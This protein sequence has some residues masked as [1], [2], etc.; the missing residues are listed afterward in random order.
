M[1]GAGGGGPRTATVAPKATGPVALPPQIVVKDLAELLDVTTNE[2][3]RDLIGIGIFAAINEVVS[4]ADAAKVAEQLGFEPEE[5]AVPAP[6]PAVQARPEAEKIGAAAHATDVGRVAR[7]PV[8]TVMGHVDHG[9]TS[10]L[11]AIRNTRVAAGEAGGITQHIG[12]YQ[13]EVNGRKVTFLDTPGHE[14]FTQMRARGAQV[15]DVAVIVVAA[16]DGVMPQ[17]IE[18]IDHARAANVPLIVALNKID[19]QNANP[20]FV[21]QQLADNNV[22]IEEY[23]GDVVLVPVSAKK[24]EGIKE[25][26]EMIL[27]VADLQDVKA[28]P[29][30][31]AQGTIIEARLD[32]ASGVTATVLIQNGS[33]KIGDIVVVGTTFGRV[34]A[35]FDDTGKRINKALPS[36][37]VSILGLSEVPSA[38]DLL[39]A[40]SDE[41]AARAL[42]QERRTTAQ[43]AA[44]Q[45]VSLDSL[46][47]QMR[48]GKVKELNLLL[49]TDVQGSVEAIRHGLTQ[50]GESHADE[51]LKVRL[52]HDAVGNVSENDVHLAAASK[53]VIIAFNVKVDSAAQRQAAV[54]GVDIRNYNVIY[55]MMDDIEAALTGL[56]EPVYRE[57][58]DGHAEVVQTFK[59]G[60]TM[61]IAGCRVTD[62][63][64]ARS[65]QVRLLRGG[66]TVF[67]GLIQSL[68]RGK[69][70][71]REVAQGFEC[72]IV[73]EDYNELE[74]GD[75]VETY[76]RVRV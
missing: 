7:A 52:I 74:V 41:K 13:V 65:S 2:V 47:M 67:T 75:V 60:R 45:S 36:M 73:L 44:G 72:G 37:P 33:L 9:K 31:K 69:D 5:A 61:I 53:A 12:A 56:L 54:D 17:T 66:K 27:L 48:E 32:P 3:I 18:A 62:G 34:R 10:L 29:N 51:G 40:V 70:D 35:M 50:L 6:A 76:S 43:A 28:N 23:G 57:Q 15:T 55:K 4:Y 64:I 1:N 16:D 8:V 58:V 68:R 71:V 21:K 25:L 24:G 46:S 20:D 30:G 49:K 59:A 19:K 63:K 22:V 11:D 14:A 39:R 26:L 42:V 38:G